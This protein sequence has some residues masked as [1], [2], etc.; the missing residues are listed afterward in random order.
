[1]SK[2]I[3]LKDNVYLSHDSIGIKIYKGRSTSPAS[4]TLPQ[5]IDNYKYLDFIF[6]RGTDYGE[7]VCRVY[8]DSGYD[9]NSGHANLFYTD[10]NSNLYLLSIKVLVHNTTVTFTPKM[11]NIFGH[12]IGT[13]NTEF[14]L[15]GIYGYK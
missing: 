1:M 13:N 10:S 9:R 12:S 4:Y 3:K 8:Y 2:S 6:T 7:A 11:C 14:F 5:N 15:I